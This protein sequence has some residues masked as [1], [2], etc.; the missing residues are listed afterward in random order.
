MKKATA[1]TTANTVAPVAKET[2]GKSNTKAAAGGLV[3]F[4]SE[5]GQSM[6]VDRQSARQVGL[7]RNMLDLSPPEGTLTFPLA[8][9]KSTIM[10]KVIEFI[11]FHQ[12]D[13]APVRNATSAIDGGII[14]E[15]DPN[16]GV[17]PNVSALRLE[18]QAEG[19]AS[20]FTMASDSS[21]SDDD[22]S[23]GDHDEYLHEE[24]LCNV[25]P[26]DQKFMDNLDLATLLELTKAANYLNVALLLDLCCRT[27]AKQM[28][29]LKA[30]ELRK[31]FNLTNDFTPEEE[32][33]MAAEFA[34]IDE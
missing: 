15:D 25:T 29:G 26:W 17:T 28:T 3:I 9:V 16:A 8:N 12:N 7:I 13:A 22:F 6:E 27:I 33:K 21:S 20:K 30:E 4:V 1:N 31:K 14:D 19:M 2:T 11:Q 32:A 5:D 23:D 34:W 18:G 10:S 24:Y